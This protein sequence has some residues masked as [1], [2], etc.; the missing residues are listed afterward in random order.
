MRLRGIS[1]KS[2]TAGIRPNPPSS[3]STRSAMPPISSVLVE[4]LG[5]NWKS[6]SYFTGCSPL[7]APRSSTGSFGGSQPG[8]IGRVDQKKAAPVGSGQVQGGNAQ[9]GQCD[10]TKRSYTALQQYG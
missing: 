10:T 3:P 6:I 8:V 1:T 4:P 7:F 2:P 5:R 9:E